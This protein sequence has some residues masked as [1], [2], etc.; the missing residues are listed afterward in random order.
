[1][2]ENEM[3]P[4]DR[5]KFIDSVYVYNNHCNSND[6]QRKK[7]KEYTANLFAKYFV[8]ANKIGGNEMKATLFAVCSDAPKELIE[9]GKEEAR[10]QGVNIID[11]NNIKPQ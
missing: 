7:L 9:R 11:Y 4:E 10:K 1:M 2:T 6:P 3:T 8:L 5:R